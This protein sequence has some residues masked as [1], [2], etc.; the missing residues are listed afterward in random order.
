[1]RSSVVSAAAGLVSGF[2]LV[3]GLGAASGWG[4]A[5]PVTVAPTT[6]SEVVAREG[7]QYFDPSE[8][9]VGQ[10]V[11]VPDALRMDGDAAV[12]TYRLEAI[13]P[14]QGQ[15]TG[16]VSQFVGDPGTAI[17]PET[18]PPVFPASWTL[19]TAGASYPGATTT[20]TSRSVRF[21]VPTRF[22][23]SQ[24]TGLRIESYRVPLP[25][26]EVFVLSEAEPVL[27]IAPGVSVSL[28]QIVDQGEQTIVQVE[29]VAEDPFNRENLTVEGVGSVWA[30]A[31]RE[32]EGRPRYNL[33]LALDETPEN[34]VL[35]VRG[36]VWLAVGGP[37]EVALGER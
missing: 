23:P 19:L 8:V 21:D 31:V 29:I 9:V 13:A 5:G 2:A 14:L 32:A 1:M 20:V 28:I 3:A 25:I 18:L 24:A 4:D 15:E 11:L 17:Q 26:S 6:T 27:E 12:F 10:A 37:I 7:P 16:Y 22:S 33:R 30:S 36:M 35:R 34:L